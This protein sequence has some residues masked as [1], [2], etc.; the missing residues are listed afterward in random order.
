MADKTYEHWVS[1]SGSL[2]IPADHPQREW[3]TKGSQLCCTF[4]A[5]GW[6]EASQLLHDHMGWEPYEPIEDTDA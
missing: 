4:H 1:G 2:M 6:N 5:Q 3:L